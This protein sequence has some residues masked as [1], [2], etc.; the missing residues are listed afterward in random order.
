MLERGDVGEELRKAIIKSSVLD[1]T[2]V[3]SLAGVLLPAQP[4]ITARARSNRRPS[5]L[6][7]SGT[8]KLGRLSAVKL[9]LSNSRPRFK[10]GI[11]MSVLA[12]S[13]PPDS[14]PVAVRRA[15]PEDAAACGQVCFDAFYKISTDHGF[16]PDFPSPDV[17]T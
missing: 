12:L 6:S 8:D 1:I 11:S 9:T 10:K 7:I 15:K 14:P 3:G 17:A 2:S 13:V 4:H 16:P 5:G